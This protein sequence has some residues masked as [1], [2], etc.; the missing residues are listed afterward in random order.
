MSSFIDMNTKRDRYFID[1]K[2]NLL[3]VSGKKGKRI[4][5]NTWG[6]LTVGCPKKPWWKRYPCNTVGKKRSKFPKR[7]GETR[8]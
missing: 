4:S 7:A 1:T 8:T 3:I 6:F 5:I 2:G